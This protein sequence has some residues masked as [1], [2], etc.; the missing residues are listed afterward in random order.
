VHASVPDAHAQRARKFLMRMLSIRIKAGVYASGSQ[1]FKKFSS[2]LKIKNF[3][4]SFLTLT[5]GLNSSPE[6]KIF[7]PNL[8]K[9]PP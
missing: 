3:K 7:G 5:N 1:I 4:K 9:K 6:K 8:E 2:T